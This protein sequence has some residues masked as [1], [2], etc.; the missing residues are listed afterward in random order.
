MFLYICIVRKECFEKITL[1]GH[2]E[3]KR[4]RGKQRVRYLSKWQA[5]HVGVEIV[6]TSNIA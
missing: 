6:R 1:P 5:E 4:G 3:S 2:F